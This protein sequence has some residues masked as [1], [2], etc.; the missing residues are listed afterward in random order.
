MSRNAVGLVIGL[1][2]LGFGA[3][4]FKTFQ[5]WAGDQPQVMQCGAYLMAPHTGWFK[6][7]GCTLDTDGIVLEN[8]QGDMEPLDNR[9]K[10]LSSKLYASPPVWVAAWIPMSASVGRNQKRGAAL[11]STSVDLLKWVAAVEAADESKR[12]KMFEDPV[13]LRR[14]V[15]P[16]LLEGHL[17]KPAGDAVAKAFGPAAS[18]NLHVMTLGQPP[19]RTHPAVSVSVGFVLLLAVILVAARFSRPPR[20]DTAA[21]TPEQQLA[22]SMISGAKVELGELED[23]R[24]EEAARRKRKSGG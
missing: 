11:R 4:A 19:E 9:R 6:L 12:E 8:E 7:E 2:V 24:A 17:E 10:G 3:W 15:R 22:R 1:A 21:E 14:M 18:V 23:I 20:L 13:V 5:D 16:G